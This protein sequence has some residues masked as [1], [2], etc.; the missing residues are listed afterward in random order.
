MKLKLTTKSQIEKRP[1]RTTAAML[2][3]LKLQGHAPI[4]PNPMLAAVT[5]RWCTKNESLKIALSF[6]LYVCIYIGSVAKC[7][8]SRRRTRCNGKHA[9]ARDALVMEVDI[10]RRVCQRLRKARLSQASAFSS[11]ARPRAGDSS[12]RR[13][14]CATRA[15]RADRGWPSQS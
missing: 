7:T 5:C 1:A 15:S 4:T 11:A 12:G 14:Q 6:F 9:H 13:F 2:L 10:R 8:P 3:K